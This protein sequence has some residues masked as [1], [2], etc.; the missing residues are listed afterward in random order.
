MLLE[1]IMEGLISEE[2]EILKDVLEQL[3]NRAMETERCEFLRGG[4]YKR[5]HKRRGHANGYKPKSTIRELNKGIY[6]IQ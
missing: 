1:T 4:P 5:T 6:S 2:P 3:F